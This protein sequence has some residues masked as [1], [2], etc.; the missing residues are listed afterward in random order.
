LAALQRDSSSARHHRHDAINGWPRAVLRTFGQLRI[1]FRQ[2]A[3]RG[4]LPG[5]RKSSR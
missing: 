3:L 1:R 2:L 4:E 5:V